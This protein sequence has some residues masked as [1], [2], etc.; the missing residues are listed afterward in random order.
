MVNGRMLT[1]PRFLRGRG[2]VNGDQVWEV[3]RGRDGGYV[4]KLSKR[5][6]EGD[7]FPLVVE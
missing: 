7:N 3:K 2:G 5:V 6:R 1:I 4:W